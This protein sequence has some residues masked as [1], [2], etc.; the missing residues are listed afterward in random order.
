MKEKD[1]EGSLTTKEDFFVEYIYIYIY[2]K[3]ER[4][5]LL[6]SHFSFVILGSLKTA[7]SWGV[8]QLFCMHV[9]I[10]S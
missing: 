4:K 3:R 6:D 8:T 7:K 10:S 2:I 1:V 9:N 5:V